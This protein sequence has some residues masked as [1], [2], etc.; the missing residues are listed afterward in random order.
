MTLWA[1][2][3]TESRI[4]GLP[5]EGGAAGGAAGGVLARGSARSAANA[6]AETDRALRA[7]T[8]LS[9]SWRTRAKGVS[10][11]SHNSVS[12]DNVSPLESV[13]TRLGCSGGAAASAGGRAGARGAGAGA[14]GF[15]RGVPSP[16]HR[17]A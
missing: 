14:A 1:P 4:M 6:A 17:L 13:A 16:L 10:R 7:R 9:A 12:W 5:A 3:A 2:N 11:V 15:A 8:P